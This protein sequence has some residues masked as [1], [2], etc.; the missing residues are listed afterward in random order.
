MLGQFQHYHSISKHIF[1]EDT[2]ELICCTLPY[3]C[4]CFVFCLFICY[5]YLLPQF[6]H[7]VFSC[8]VSWVNGRVKLFSPLLQMRYLLFC[9]LSVVFFWKCE[10]WQLWLPSRW[11]HRLTLLRIPMWTCSYWTY[12]VDYDVL[13]VLAIRLLQ[14]LLKTVDWQT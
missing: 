1:L 10:F 3:N 7:L 11:Q 8:V 12:I 2:D 13:A 9:T 6:V 5:F 4:C 14:Q